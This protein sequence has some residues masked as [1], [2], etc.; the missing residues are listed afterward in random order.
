[1]ICLS[2]HLWL[3]ELFLQCGELGIKVHNVGI[4]GAGALW[5]MKKYKYEDMKPEIYEKIEKWE[6]LI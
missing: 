4:F 1:M 3:H 5:G 6:A 2:I